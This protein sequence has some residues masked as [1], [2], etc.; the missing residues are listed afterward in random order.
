LVIFN[1]SYNYCTSKSKLLSTWSD[2]RNSSQ[3]YKRPAG[4]RL[5]LNIRNISIK[6]QHITN[7]IAD[8]RTWPR[9]TS[10]S[11]TVSDLPRNIIDSD[12]ITRIALSDRKTIRSSL[13][14]CCPSPVR[15]IKSSSGA[16]ER[17][18]TITGRNGKPPRIRVGANISVRSEGTSLSSNQTVSTIQIGIVR[19][20]SCAQDDRQFAN[21]NRRDISPNGQCGGFKDQ[22]P[23]IGS[24]VIKS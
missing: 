11:R 3:I 24:I 20:I 5:I 4:S 23:I 6:L 18:S 19:T 8:R 16:C 15:A 14:S 7:C 1:G 21:T 13:I 2:I 9:P 17:N 12:R 10:T 22:S